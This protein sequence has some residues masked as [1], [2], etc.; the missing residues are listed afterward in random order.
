MGLTVT[1]STN[2]QFDAHMRKSL[3]TFADIV[4]RAKVSID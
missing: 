4:A 1:G 2:E 3:K